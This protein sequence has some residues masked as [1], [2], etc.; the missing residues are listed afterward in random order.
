MSARRGNL[1]VDDGRLFGFGLLLGALPLPRTLVL[2]LALGLPFPRSHVPRTLAVLGLGTGA[3]EQPARHERHGEK[4]AP[5][6]RA[7]RVGQ[8]TG[9]ACVHGSLPIPA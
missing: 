3:P 2:L 9:T 8:A 1:S 5:E 6:E 4:K 7:G